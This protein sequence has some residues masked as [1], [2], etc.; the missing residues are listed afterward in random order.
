LESLE[1][2]GDSLVYTDR[3]AVFKSQTK[4]SQWIMDHAKKARKTYTRKEWQE[5]VRGPTPFSPEEEHL[6]RARKKFKWKTRGVTE[7]GELMIEVSNESDMVLPFLTFDVV[8]PGRNIVGGEYLNVSGIKPGE[9]SVLTRMSYC[10]LSDLNQIE[11]DLAP[12]P[13][14]EDRDCY[15]EFKN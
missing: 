12:E 4:F 10:R 3:Y 1:S 5:I 15:W 14:P 7:D 9:T 13:W 6:L 8:F 2:T 11:I